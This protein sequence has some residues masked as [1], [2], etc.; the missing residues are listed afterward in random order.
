M[1]TYT[2]LAINDNNKGYICIA[3]N[4]KQMKNAGINMRLTWQREESYEKA[5]NE[6]KCSN[7]ELK[8]SNDVTNFSY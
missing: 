2:Y 6:L 4:K 5:I 8:A 7:A 1:K 3:H